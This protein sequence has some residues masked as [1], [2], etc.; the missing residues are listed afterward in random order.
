ML[1]GGEKGVLLSSSGQN[2]YSSQNRR[3]SRD[4]VWSSNAIYF[5][6]ARQR[7]PDR[8]KHVVVGSQEENT[9]LVC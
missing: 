8:V 2:Q 9:G 7:I 1:V 5:P 3:V 4:L 6:A